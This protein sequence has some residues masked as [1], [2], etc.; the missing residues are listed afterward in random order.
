MT[1]TNEKK[2]AE[3]Q[4]IF[5][6]KW[7]VEQWGNIHTFLDMRCQ[8]NRSEGELKRDVEQK[9]KDMLKRSPSL[10]SCHTRQFRCSRLR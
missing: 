1:G 5:K 7:S 2:I 10:L 3:L 4:K 6:D 8:Y 9:I